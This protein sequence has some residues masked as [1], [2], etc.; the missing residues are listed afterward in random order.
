MTFGE[1]M[2]FDILLESVLFPRQTP[3]SIFLPVMRQIE[4]LKY[5]LFSLIDFPPNLTTF[6]KKVF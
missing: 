4:H 1:S 5:W 3:L 6:T 2:L